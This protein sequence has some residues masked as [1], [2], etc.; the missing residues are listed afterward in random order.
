MIFVYNYGTPLTA[1]QATALNSFVALATTPAGEHL[2]KDANGEFVNTPDTGGGGSGITTLNG[3][4]ATTQTFADVDDTNVTLAINSATST[5]TFTL[6][7]T[8]T[9]AAGRLNSN[10]VQAVSNDTNVT[11]SISTQTL[12]LGWTGTLAVSRGGLGASLASLTTNNLAKYNGTNFVDSLLAS[13]VSGA[14]A[15]FAGTLAGDRT[16]T[17]PDA[18]G[19]VALLAQDANFNT[20]TVNTNL[21]PDTNDGAAL[22]TTALQFSDLFLA[23]G[24]VINWDNGD[25]TLTQTNNELV[26]AGG[27]LDIG[28]NKLRIGGDIDIDGTPASD[29]TWT[30]PSTNSFNA[31]ATIAQWEAVYLDTS[32]TWQLTDAD[33]ASTA[34][35]VLV[36]IATEAGT[37]SNPLRVALPGSFVRNDA[38]TWTVGAPVYLSTTAGALTQTAPSGTDDVVRVVG[39]AVNADVLFWNPSPDYITRT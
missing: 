21:V 36:G 26:L 22:G 39:F 31:G 14:R 25:L 29:D 23:E 10:V 16:Y 13:T 2:A 24:A 18:S 8:G 35:S 7:W 38:W 19:T 9:L 33:A 5:H 27:N 3:L 32:S 17:L 20:L 6:G 34:G 12:T 11:G 4:T 28:T 30:G 37:S 1:A 15:I